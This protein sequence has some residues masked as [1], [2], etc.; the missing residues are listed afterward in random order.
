MTMASEPLHADVDFDQPLLAFPREFLAQQ[1]E[2]DFF[3]ELGMEPEYRA[4]RV[5]DKDK[6]PSVSSLLDEGEALHGTSSFC[7]G[8]YQH[9]KK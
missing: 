4:P 6:G 1:K 9:G 8:I 3:N 7:R 2:A 5:L